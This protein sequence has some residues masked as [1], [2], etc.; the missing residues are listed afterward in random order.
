MAH[1]DCDYGIKTAQSYLAQAAEDGPNDKVQ[2]N[3]KLLREKM[4]RLKE[5]ITELQDMNLRLLVSHNMRLEVD[6]THLFRVPRSQT[7]RHLHQHAELEILPHP[8]PKT[9]VLVSK[10]GGK[11][12]RSPSMVNTR[13]ILKL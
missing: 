2:E 3:R 7:S 8:E 5:L 12:I 13:L 10:S 9:A 11:L 6:S 1:D 4:E